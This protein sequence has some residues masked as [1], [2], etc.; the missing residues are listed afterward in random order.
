MQ[1]SSKFIRLCK[2][3]NKCHSHSPFQSAPSQTA[4]LKYHGT[5]LQQITLFLER[6]RGLDLGSSYYLTHV[7]VFKVPKEE[8]KLSATKQSHSI[9]T[10]NLNALKLEQGIMSALFAR[11]TE[12]SL[13][14][15]RWVQVLLLHPHSSAHRG[16]AHTA[17]PHTPHATSSRPGLAPT[18]PGHPEAALLSPPDTTQDNFVA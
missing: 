15:Q 10:A 11:R 9:H 6:F 3:I 12:P 1:A 4:R 13:Q 8:K 16:A 5:D 17:P 7:G 2:C 18:P 14:L